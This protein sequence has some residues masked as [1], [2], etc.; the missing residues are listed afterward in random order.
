LSDANPYRITG[1]AVISFSGGRSSGYM[2]RKILDAHDGVLPADVVVGF[3]NTGKERP[4]TLDFV[5]ECG[6]RWG[7][8]IVWLEFDPDAE[9]STAIVSHNS[10]SRDGGPFMAAIV[11]RGFLP[12]PV[13]RFCTV[14]LKIRRAY[15][16]AHKILGWDRWVSVVGFRADEMSRVAKMGRSRERWTNV[17]PMAAA[18]VTKRDVA[19]FWRQQPFDLRLPNINGATPDGN[20]DLCFLKSAP[21]IAGIMRRRPDSARWW[22]G[23]EAL[24]LASKPS[25]ARF[26]NDRAGYA[27]MLAAVQAQ[28]DFAEMFSDMGGESVDCACHD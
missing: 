28:G 25:G 14:E 13:T 20:C 15:S 8:H 10:A 4:E 2:L 5:A 18:G 19:E 3:C 21:T 27:E 1:P 11:K 23:A 6:S 16:Y 24:A 22:I 12:N 9:H 26:R 17:A 7:V